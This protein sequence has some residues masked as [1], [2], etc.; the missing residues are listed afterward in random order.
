MSDKPIA[1]LVAALV[2]APLCAA[3]IL[4]PVVLGSMIAGMWGW[5]S[6]NGVL[7]AAAVV[8]V[9]AVLGYALKRRQS[10]QPAASTDARTL[11]ARRTVEVPGG[12]RRE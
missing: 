6:G 9:V 5:F 1:L 10:R 2:V 7:V 4:G 8:I 3:C 11:A 12:V